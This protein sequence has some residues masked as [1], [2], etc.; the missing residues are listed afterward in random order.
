MDPENLP[1]GWR[2]GSVTDLSDLKVGGDKPKVISECLTRKCNIPIYSNGVVDEG[3]YGYTNNASISLPSFTISARGT[4][5]KCFLRLSPYYSIVRLIS[6]IPKNVDTLLY[7]FFYFSNQKIE[8][9]GSVQNQL[10]I[11]FL[12]SEEMVIPDLPTMTTF[13]SKVLPLYRSTENIHTEIA[14]LERVLLV[15]LSKLSNNHA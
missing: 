6:V 9:E 10:T 1:E 4:I 12:T 8:G 13:N 11:P 7:Q 14:L 2:I 15:L 5:G 3:L